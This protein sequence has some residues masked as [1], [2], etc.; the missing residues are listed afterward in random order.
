MTWTI[1]KAVPAHPNVIAHAAQSPTVTDLSIPRPIL[2][3]P[4]V[5][6]GSAGTAARHFD[7]LRAAFAT[8]PGSCLPRFF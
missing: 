1:Q 7:E 2:L 4:Y 6:Y 3:P 8:R 5:S